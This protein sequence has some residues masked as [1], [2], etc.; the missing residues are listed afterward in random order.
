MPGLRGNSA[1]PL[2]PGQT[3][4]RAATSP[5]RGEAGDPRHSASACYPMKYRGMHGRPCKYVSGSDESCPHGTEV[6]YFWKYETP[7]G[8]YYYVDCCGRETTSSVWCN[9]CK[10]P[11]WCLGKGGNIYTCTMAIAQNN[12]R[13]GADGFPS[14]D[15]IPVGPP[16]AGPIPGLPAP[17]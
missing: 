10:E 7:V 4:P 13:M 15:Y 2:S 17:R 1:G 9:W 3:A 6:G 5:H 11:N 14:T 16:T 8:V 12:L